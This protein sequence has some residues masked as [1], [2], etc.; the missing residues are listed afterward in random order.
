MPYSQ[1]TADQLD[2][3]VLADFRELSRFGETPRG[4]VDREALTAPDV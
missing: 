3:E 2:A 1:L 4:G